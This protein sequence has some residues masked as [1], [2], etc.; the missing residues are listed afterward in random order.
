MSPIYGCPEEFCL[1]AADC[2]GDF[3]CLV[4]GCVCDADQM[5]NATLNGKPHKA[6][7]QCC[8]DEN[9]KQYLGD[10]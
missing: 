8:L 9:K 3:I 6:C 5:G 4:C 10:L 1:N 2:E 7:N